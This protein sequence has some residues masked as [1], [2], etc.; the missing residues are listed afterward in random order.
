VSVSIVVPMKDEEGAFP[1]LALEIEQLRGL[2]ADRGR[3]LEV[4][5]VDDGSTDGTRGLAEAWCAAGEGRKLLRHETNRG[6]GAGLRTGVAATTGDAVVS[7]DADCAY[8]AADV[9]RLVE[10]LDDGADVASAT[11]FAEGAEFQVGPFRRLLS[12]GCSSLYRAALRG[13]AKGVRTFTCAFRAYRGDLIRRFSWDAD[14][15]V[16][17]AEILSRLLAGGSRVV[18]VPCSLRRRTAG[19]SKMRV[20][21]TTS[22]HL[23]HLARLAFGGDATSTPR[24][25]APDRRGT[26]AGAAIAFAA[27]LVVYL[28]VVRTTSFGFVNY[29]D[30]RLVSTENPAIGQGLVGGLRR[31]LNPTAHP[32]FMDAWLPLYYWSVGLDHKLGH[33]DA[34]IFHLHSALLHALGAAMVVMIARRL[35]AS[36]LVAG[37]AGVI[38]AVHPAATESVAWVASRKD[39]LSFTWMAAAALFYLDGVAKRRPASHAL[40]AACLLVSMTAKGT[41]LVL[42]PLLVVHALLL[43][44]DGTK[45]ERLAPV[46]PYAVV[47]AAMTGLHMWVAS[48]EQTADAVG[49]ASLGAILVADLQVAW[50]Y[51]VALF[52][53]AHWTL[54]VEHGLSA[55]AVDASQAFLGAVILVVWV[56]AVA[57]TWKTHRRVAA[58]LVAVPVALLPFNNLLP[59][60][61]VLFAERYCYVALLPVAIGAAWMLRPRGD[62]GGSLVPAAIG[63]G[64]L[65]TFCALRLPVWRDSVALWADASKK[66]P[67][68]AVVECQL[69]DAYRTASREATGPDAAEWS[70]RATEAWRSAKALATNGGSDLDRLR[71][72]AGLAGQ[73]LAGA[74]AAKDP[75]QQVKDAAAGFETAANLAEKLNV[76]GVKETRVELA[77]NLATCDELLGDTPTALARWQRVVQLDAKCAPGWNALARLSLAAG[78]KKDVKDAIEKSAAAE[79]SDPLVVHERAKIRLAAGD[80]GGAKHDLAT[81]IAANPK[82]VDL[83]LEAARLDLLILRPADAAATLRKA[84]DLRPDDGTVRE[85]LALALLEQAESL[86]SHEDIAG[87]REL[88][89]Q[90]AEAAPQSDA[91]EKVLGMVERRSGDLEQAARHLRKARDL[92]PDG[93]RTKEQLASVLAELAV[94]MLDDGREGMAQIVL[95]EAVAVRADV[96]ATPKARLDVGVED[97]PAP[98]TGDD[99]ADVVRR[100]ALKGLAYLSA[101]RAAAAA[102]ELR[103]AD[104]GTKD[105]DAHLRRVVLE[106]FVRA[107]FA[108]GRPDEAVAAARDLPSIEIADDVAWKWKRQD[109]LAVALI[110]RGTGRRGTKTD[111]VGAK[112]DFDAAR[113][114]LEAARAAGAPEAKI[115]V[116]LGEILF[117][118]E[119]FLAATK[120]FD[121]AEE[122]AKTDLDPLLDRAAVWRTQ[123]L[124]E[125]EKS[126][127]SAA[128][129]DYRRA[130]E[131]APSDPRVLA[132]LGEILFFAQKPSEAFPL[133]QKAVLADPSQAGARRLLAEIAIRAGRAHLEKV[134]QNASSKDAKS[135]LAEARSAA[136]R[137]VAFDPP[138]PDALLFLGDVMRAQG[139]WTGP[140]AKYELAR[141]RFPDATAPL[142]SIAKFHMDRGS[143]MWLLYKKRAEAIADLTQAIATP[144]TTV[145][146]K[147]AHERLHDIAVAAF[148]E[149]MDL[150]KQGRPTEAAERFATSISAEPTAEAH[151]A[152][153]VVLAKA[154]RLDDAL[155]EY[156]AALKMNPK[157]LDARLNQAGTLRRLGRLDEAADAYRAWLADAPNDD[158]SRAR[159]TRQVEQIDVE[160]REDDARKSPTK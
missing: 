29:D 114:A 48:R 159:V 22:A 105:G 110:E 45:R 117:R 24:T 153:G 18:E 146:L 89:R 21:A 13:K 133:L 118:E 50:R 100:A 33:G 143:F 83:L 151:F 37:L 154:E 25:D 139:D 6:F 5:L 35:G 141:D 142:D 49:A 82:N 116:R 12:S 73:L 11:P 101:G 112:E 123:Y 23:R 80:L 38:F 68:S 31:L 155:P 91:P 103:L 106:L 52:A 127:L 54:S 96:I 75:A 144:K 78:R 122:L 136:E 77:R 149:A 2:L 56:G 129:H 130:S 55:D 109:Q 58:F 120:E 111:L 124:I 132:G 63:V 20:V 113:A 28:A 62:G 16:A 42:A 61:T 119:D 71:A 27:A 79:P 53:P 1:R 147:P 59:R 108:D 39:V 87:A 98:A 9:V 7:Y 90:A 65:A 131:I 86:A 81:A 34:W 43:R 158:P 14:G 51:F 64:A 32:Q 138:T 3:S 36:A 99:R 145:D 85:L 93:V 137:A 135:E 88:A 60:T 76:R 121:K 97:W 17:A 4:V 157:M 15:F 67:Q 107:L 94:R 104:A 140:L 47:A 148:G 152:R 74:G 44:D 156:E 92:H 84:V 150:D 125:E 57:A 30:P 134:A 102:S 70:E 26:W 126:Y 95:E 41:T 160:R 10:K 128:E 69:A 66:A 19:V 40:G 8:A 115:R 72:E 46:V